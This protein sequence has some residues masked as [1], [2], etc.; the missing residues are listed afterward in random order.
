MKAELRGKFIALSAFL[1]KWESSYTNKLKVYLKALEKKREANTPS[2]RQQEIIKLK[3]NHSIRN[4]ENNT[5]NQGN[6]KLIPRFIKLKVKRE[7]D[8]HE[9]QGTISTYFKNLN[10][11]KLENLN[12]MD[13]FLN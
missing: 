8:S 11:T 10:S 9:I 3:L 13:D 4:K 2:S 1:K 7:G 6:L 12:E 5:K